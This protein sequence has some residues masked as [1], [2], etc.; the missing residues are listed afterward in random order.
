MG[1][2]TFNPASPLEMSI[3]YIQIL[4]SA[5]VTVVLEKFSAWEDY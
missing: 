2:L 5:Y 4:N 3:K 1:V